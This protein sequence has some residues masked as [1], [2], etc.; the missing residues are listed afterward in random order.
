MGKEIAY[1]FEDAFE[2]QEGR[3]VSDADSYNE[4]YGDDMFIQPAKPRGN[5]GFL[6]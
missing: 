4:Q 3:I 1:A 5:T 6:F 2:G